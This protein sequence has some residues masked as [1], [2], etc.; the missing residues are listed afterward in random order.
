MVNAKA[1]KR[2]KIIC[3]II[4]ALCTLALLLED[5]FLI[6]QTNNGTLSSKF[7]EASE[8]TQRWSA[9]AGLVIMT[10][11]I[12]PLIFFNF[13][14]TVLSLVTTITLSVYVLKNKDSE[15]HKL[16]YFT[17]LLSTVHCILLI[18]VLLSWTPSLAY[19][20]NIFC[21]ALNAILIALTISYRKKL[22]SINSAQGMKN[23]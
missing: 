1:I 3:C 11:A 18:I 15:I 23:V 17:A 16:I 19:C 6:I 7:T 5:V 10:F 9:I 8:E 20:A 22:K 21:I 4:C 12:M 14:Y 13:G 2:L